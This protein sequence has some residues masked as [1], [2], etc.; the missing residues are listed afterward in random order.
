MSD[1]NTRS[2]AE[3]IGWTADRHEHRCCHCFTFPDDMLAW[4]GE[5]KGLD[6]VITRRHSDRASVKVSDPRSRGEAVYL[7]AATVY[8]ALEAAVRAVD[9]D[10]DRWPD[11]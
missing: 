9:A 10:P 2:V 6:V 5:Q 1:P 3:I 8:A 4:L 11:T 7:G